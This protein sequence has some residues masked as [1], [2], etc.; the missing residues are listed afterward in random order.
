[1]WK[2]LFLYE[3]ESGVR[4]GLGAHQIS[5]RKSTTIPMEWNARDK[6]GWPYININPSGEGAHL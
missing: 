3:K 6:L 5:E 2:A 1:M 4:L